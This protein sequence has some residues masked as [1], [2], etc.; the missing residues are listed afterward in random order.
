MDDFARLRHL[1]ETQRLVNSAS[2]VTDEL[3]ETVSERAR[4]ITEADGG[5][6][7]LLDG[8]ELVCRASTGSMQGSLGRRVNVASTI[9]G[10]CARLAVPMRC[11]D[12]EYDTRV[13]RAGSRRAG[14][15]SMVVVPVMKDDA[16]GGVLKVVS[17]RPDHF[18]DSDV[19]VLQ[20]MAGLIAKVVTRHPAAKEW[21][22]PHG[23]VTTRVDRRLCLERLEQACATADRDGTALAV[24]L[25]RLNGVEPAQEGLLRLVA[26]ALTKVVRE[27]D[28]LIRMGDDFALACSN[29]GEIDAY[30]TMARVSSAVRRAAESSPGHEHVSAA[31]GVAWRDAENRSPEQLLSAASAAFVKAG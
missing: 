18:S 20:E 2:L 1:A 3:L 5:M 10:R 24:F 28:L 17:A 13:D 11:V 23:H 4:E 8:D 31:V 15:R 9:S 26:D 14:V 25:I 16:A 22:G 6:V 30:G 27:G 19:E 21:E 7:E 29:A 12:T